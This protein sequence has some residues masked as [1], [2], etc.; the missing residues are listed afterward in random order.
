MTASETLNAVKRKHGRRHKVAY[1]LYEAL[2]AQ[3]PIRAITLCDAAGKVVAH[4]A[5]SPEH[6][7]AATAPYPDEPSSRG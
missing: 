5:P 4:H 3:D 2:V 1:R 6:D 7:A